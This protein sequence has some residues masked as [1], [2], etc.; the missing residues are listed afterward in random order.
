MWTQ[1]AGVSHCSR[2]CPR[3]RPS[4]SVYGK[5]S[6]GWGNVNYRGQ[7]DAP[8]SGQGVPGPCSPASG[9]RLPGRPLGGQ[10]RLS[11][12]VPVVGDAAELLLGATGPGTGVPVKPG[13]TAPLGPDP[14][15]REPRGHAG[16]TLPGKWFLEPGGSAPGSVPHP[17][18]VG[19]QLL[20]DAPPRVP[21]LRC[22]A[23]QADN[24]SFPNPRRRLRLQDLADRVVDA[25]EDEHEL[26]QLL[27][28]ALLERE[29][30]QV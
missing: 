2:M 25:S 7:T 20:P 23:L 15:G 27:N 17:N 28:E 11:H 9:V 18:P 29:S 26:N 22:T 24:P 14:M 19:P 8:A 4:T 30:A 21:Q 12:T 1:L 6:R 13:R 5:E 16:K 10:R 3:D